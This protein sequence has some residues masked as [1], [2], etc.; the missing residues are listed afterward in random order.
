MRSIMP[1]TL[2]A[3]L[4]LVLLLALAALHLLILGGA[5][6]SEIVWG[7]QATGGSMLLLE[8]VALLTTLLFILAVWLR[9]R[10]LRQGRQQPVLR[11][12]LWVMFAYFLL[13]SAANFTSA[14]RLEALVFGPFA[15]LA[16]LLTLRLAL[17]K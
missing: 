7:G 5:V 16:A 8:S 12:A 1:P 11:L 6:P 3:T 9:L 14:V 15:L 2:A 10:A 17:V 13:N 4:L